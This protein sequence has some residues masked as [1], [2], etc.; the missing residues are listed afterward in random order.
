MRAIRRILW[1][2]KKYSK[3]TETNQVWLITVKSIHRL[4]TSSNRYP[5]SRARTTGRAARW[6]RASPTSSTIS[7]YRAVAVHLSW[8]IKCW[9]WIWSC[10]WQLNSPQQLQRAQ[11]LNSLS[12]FDSPWP[13]SRLQPGCKVSPLV[14]SN[15]FGQTVTKKSVAVTLPITENWVKRW[16]F[17][18]KSV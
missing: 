4:C 9:H 14:W 10:T 5:S 8:T 3:I 6:R 11:L 13:D 18:T 12:A 16:I 2:V 7:L 1:F 15:F 17:L